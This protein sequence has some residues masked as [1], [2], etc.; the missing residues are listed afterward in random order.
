MKLYYTPGACSLAPHLLLEHLELPYEAV[1]VKLDAHTYPG[2]D[3]YQINPKGSVPALELDGG[4]ILTENAVILQYLADQ[5]PE[6]RSLPQ[7]GSLERYRALEWLNYI[8]TELHKNFGPLFNS[9]APEEYKT[10]A[11]ENIGKRFEFVAKRLGAQSFLAGDHFSAPDAYLFVMLTW[12][13]KM[14]IDTSRWPELGRYA[15]RIKS[16]PAAQRALKAEGLS[17]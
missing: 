9:R 6:A 8:A 13:D 10:I 14:K 11:K 2:G 3:Y 12:A 16:L 17:L 5:K 15:E 7:S 4:E 1:P